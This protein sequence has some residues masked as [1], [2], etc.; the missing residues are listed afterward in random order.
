MHVSAP[1]FDPSNDP[2]GPDRSYTTGE[3]RKDRIN[4]FDAKGGGSKEGMT[5]L[6][7]AYLG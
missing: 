6:A 7:F 2:P 1:E 3:G 4:D 5:S